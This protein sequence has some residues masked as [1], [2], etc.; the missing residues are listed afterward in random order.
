MSNARYDP[1]LRS[2]LMESKNKMVKIRNRN[3]IKTSMRN[4]SFVDK[5]I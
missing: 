4:F 1:I 5:K 3:L 2:F